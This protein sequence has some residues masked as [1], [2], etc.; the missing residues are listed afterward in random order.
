MYWDEL[1]KLSCCS[2]MNVAKNIEPETRHDFVTMLSDRTTSL[3]EGTLCFSPVSV[4]HRLGLPLPEKTGL[5]LLQDEALGENDLSGVEHAGIF[6]SPD[7]FQHCYYDVMDRYLDYQKAARGL[8][9]IYDLVAKNAGVQKIVD[10]IA[11]IYQAPVSV[12]NNAY[13]FVASSRNYTYEGDTMHREVSQGFLSPATKKLFDSFETMKPRKDKDEVQ[14]VTGR[15]ENGELLR[16]YLAL[17]HINNVRVGIVSVVC[18]ERAPFP[19][20]KAELLGDIAYALAL[21]MQKNSFYVLN[22]GTYFNSL[23][24]ELLD[25]AVPPG[26]KEFGERLHSFGYELKSLKRIY[27]VD[28]HQ[29]R[30]GEFELMSLADKLHDLIRNSIYTVR[31]DAILFLSSMDHVETE[32]E[33]N[34][35]ALDRALGSSRIRAGISVIFTDVETVQIHIREARG[36]IETGMTVDPQKNVFRFE[37]YQILDLVRCATQSVYL[38]SYYYPPLMELL[39]YDH[40]KGTHLTK[41]LRAY[42]KNPTQTDEVCAGLF[43]HRNTLYYRLEKINSIMNV[44]IRDGEVIARIEMTFRMLEYQ[45][46]KNLVDLI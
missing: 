6:T 13:A 19:R 29:E 27:Y 18:E 26:T 8:Q 43:I 14:I 12:F 37:D 11:A 21:E 3:A 2:T 44:D 5:I 15:G 40:Q 20:D 34:L 23:F 7:D 9:R 1:L 35:D 36:A 46:E 39:A 24:T 42:L 32:E 22:R 33:N 45:N 28:L 31:E 41:T 30:F 4:Y 25:S 17:I 10:A 16:N 38:G